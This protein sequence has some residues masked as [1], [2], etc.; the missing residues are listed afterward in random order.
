MCFLPYLGA[1]YQK[2]VSL[3]IVQLLLPFK[4][5]VTEA[6]KKVNTKNLVN[7]IFR[8]PTLAK[9]AFHTGTKNVLAFLFRRRSH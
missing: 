6:K 7:C 9:I 2:A 3:I 4:F 1:E 8:S 5:I